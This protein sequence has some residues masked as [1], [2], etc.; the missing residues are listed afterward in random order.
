MAGTTS[1]IPRRTPAA[2]RQAVRR[3]RAEV[4]GSDDQG[5]PG[6][7]RGTRVNARRSSALWKEDIQPI[8]PPP[9]PPRPGPAS[10][11]GQ[12]KGAVRRLGATGSVGTR[13]GSRMRNRRSPGPAPVELLELRLLVALAHRVVHVAGRLVVPRD[14]LV[15]A[16]APR[17]VL[18]APDELGDLSAQAPTV[19]LKP[20]I[21]AS[22]SR[23]ASRSEGAGRIV[24]G[25]PAT[26]PNLGLQGRDL[27]LKRMT[28]GYFGLY[29]R[30]RSAN[31]SS[32][33]PASPPGEL[34]TTVRW[35]RPCPRPGRAP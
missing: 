30:L 5:D 23:S 10:R 29:R 22:T 15:V 32:C 13:A 28:S 18:E 26:L 19:A 33:G 4:S 3:R 2:A 14:L 24:A 7:Y 1:A 8:P 16:L 6:G 35:P 25:P 12:R 31:S 34:G 27:L 11:P 21:S 9:P 20:A 17:H